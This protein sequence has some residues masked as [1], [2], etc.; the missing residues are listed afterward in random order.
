MHGID[1]GIAL[2][3][4]KPGQYFTKKQLA[5]IFSSISR[6]LSRFVPTAEDALQL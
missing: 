4:T 5:V 6:I 2:G 3:P 1:T